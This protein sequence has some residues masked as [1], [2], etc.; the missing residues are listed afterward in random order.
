[1]TAPSMRDLLNTISDGPQHS[2]LNDDIQRAIKSIRNLNESRAERYLDRGFDRLARDILGENHYV[3][4]EALN[5]NVSQM[6]PKVMSGLKK[7]GAT[8]K[9][10]IDVLNKLRKVAPVFKAAIPLVV[11]AM[12]VMG[13]TGETKALDMTLGEL[14]QMT[15]QLMAAEEAKTNDG[16]RNDR[17]ENLKVSSIS[18]PIRW[19]N[20]MT[21]KAL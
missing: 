11:A 7:A 3:Y 2:F 15:Q 17:M 8:G 4:R 20:I 6:V 16:D 12:T 14:Q 21:K 19:L 1:M 10:L 9:K 13:S 5:E 18:K